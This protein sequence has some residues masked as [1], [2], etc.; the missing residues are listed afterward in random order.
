[1]FQKKEDSDSF[2][3]ELRF[4]PYQECTIIPQI[5]TDNRKYTEPIRQIC[6]PDKGV[7]RQD[8]FKDVTRHTRD[9][10]SPPRPFMRW[11]SLM[12]PVISPSTNKDD[13]QCRLRTAY[14]RDRQV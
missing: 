3:F 4:L 11:K 5:S 9:S 14:R 7:F 8:N 10:L 1:M 12:N 6:T 13:T 2:L